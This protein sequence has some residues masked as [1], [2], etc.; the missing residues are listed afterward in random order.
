MS[1]KFEISSEDA[2]HLLIVFNFIT[3]LTSPLLGLY[4]DNAGRN[5]TFVTASVITG[6][7]GHSLLAFTMISAYVAMVCNL[8][9]SI[10]N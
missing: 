7:I 6:I 3:M 4:V 9:L 8:H 5:L 10:Y 2:R 1:T